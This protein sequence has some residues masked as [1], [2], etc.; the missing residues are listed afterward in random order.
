MRFLSGTTVSALSAAA[1][2]LGGGV[3]PAAADPPADP[4]TVEDFAYPG[5]AAILSAHDVKLVSGDGHILFADCATPPVDGVSVMKVW[6]TEPIRSGGGG[7]VCFKVTADRGWLTLEVPGVYEI[8]GDGQRTG[9]GH[10]VTAEVTTDAGQHTTVAVNP[11][12]STQVGIGVDQGN[13]PTTLLR[14]AAGGAARPVVAD[15]PYGFGAKVDVGGVRAC[16]GALVAPQWIVTAAAC[17]AEEG[18]PAGAGAP[19]RTTTVTVGG[20]V[21]PAVR[22]VPHADRDVVLVRL[23]VRAIGV[24]PVPV[25]TTAPAGGEALRAAGFGRTATEWVPGR[26]HTTPVTVQAVAAGTVDLP[27]P[28]CKGDAG[29]PLLRSAGGRIELVAIHHTSWQRGCLGSDETRQGAVE[30]RL[31]DLAGWI[32]QVTAPP[33]EAVRMFYEYGGAQTRIFNFTGLAGSAEVAASWDSGPGSWD[34]ARGKPVTADFD[35]DGSAEVAV[36]YDYGNGQTK[37][38]L[39]ENLDGTPTVRQVWDSGQGNWEWSRSKFV[40]GDFDGDGKAEIGGFYNYDG[41]LTRLFVFGSVPGQVDIRVAWD[42]GHGNWDWNRSK[43]VSGDFDGDG[44]AEIGAYYDYGNAQT[45]LWLFDP[46]DGRPTT[47]VAWDSGPGNWE[48]ARGRPAAGA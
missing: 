29:G 26:L 39:F 36:F 24:T 45:R 44:K 12:G 23:R 43:F 47:R 48:W 34:A 8:R 30:T 11:S 1:L 13:A 4:S 7:L 19:P 2:I 14:L 20:R 15:D 5:A 22:L 40:S 46:V 6:T 18:R 33:A 32:G 31:D 21:I 9:T 16:S 42:S 38:W 17:F 10:A 37:L 3:T 28:I 41:G 25:A 35:G 27:G